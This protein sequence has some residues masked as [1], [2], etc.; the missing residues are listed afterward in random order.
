MQNDFIFVDFHG[1]AIDE[2][3]FI[4]LYFRSGFFFEF[5]EVGKGCLLFF[6]GHSPEHNY[7]VGEKENISFHPLI[8]ADLGMEQ[9]A[10][11]L[12]VSCFLLI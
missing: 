5:F 11:G 10:V 1:V 12:G 8:F 2:G 4:E 9:I 6:D 7:A 3:E